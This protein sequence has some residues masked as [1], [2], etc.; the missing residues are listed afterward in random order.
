MAIWNKL[1]RILSKSLNFPSSLRGEPCQT[2]NFEVE[3]IINN[4]R[5]TRKCRDHLPDMKK[6]TDVPQDPTK[7]INQIRCIKSRFPAWYLL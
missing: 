1:F 5:D 4:E 6:T 7:Q 2:S 3:D